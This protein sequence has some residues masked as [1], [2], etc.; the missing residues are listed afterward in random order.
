MG[1]VGRHHARWKDPVS[2]IPNGN[3]GFRRRRVYSGRIPRSW[4]RITPFSCISVP[5]WA[6]SLGW[7]GVNL[8][9]GDPGGSLDSPPIFISA[10]FDQVAHRIVSSKPLSRWLTYQDG[11]P[12]KMAHYSRRPCGIR[13]GILMC[14][15]SAEEFFRARRAPHFAVFSTLHAAPITRQ[16]VVLAVL[17][18][19]I[20]S[21]NHFQDGSPI[22][23]AH[24]SRWLTTTVHRAG[25]VLAF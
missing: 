18:P 15:M 8:V 5:F 12:I 17:D 24:L 19:I 21:S 22:Q 16:N 9:G 2:Y 4:S 23:M 7:G 11:S 3:L 10:V 14:P 25:S 1:A 20:V 6:C 13:F